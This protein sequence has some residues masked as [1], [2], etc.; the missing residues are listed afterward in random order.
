[1]KTLQVK[2]KTRYPHAY[3]ALESALLNY[4][5]DHDLEANPVEAAKHCIKFCNETFSN[6]S[7]HQ[8]RIVYFLQDLGLGIPY[9][10]EDILEMARLDGQIKN[11]NEDRILDGYWRFMSMRL[12]HVSEGKMIEVES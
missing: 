5:D 4:A 10:N 12:I 7:N 3:D 1:M 9:M 8:E 6:I 11:G 2:F